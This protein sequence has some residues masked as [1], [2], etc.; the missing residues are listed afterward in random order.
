MKILETLNW[1]NESSTMFYD[2]DLKTII[3]HG[4]WSNN[5]LNYFC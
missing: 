5:W 1:L 3:I 4:G 2:Y